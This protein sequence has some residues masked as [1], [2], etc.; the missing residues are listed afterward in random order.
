MPHTPLILVIALGALALPGAAQAGSNNLWA[1]VNICDTEAHPSMMGVRARMPGDGTHER[2][3]M[4]FTAQY[5]GDERWRTVAG[6]GT[7]RWLFVGS[8]RFRFQEIGYT[9]KFT[10]PEEGR[11]YVLRGLVQFQWRKDGKVVHRT[12]LYTQR[13]HASTGADPKG[14]SAKYCRIG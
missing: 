7:S 8:A 1:T 14:Y 5:R 2:M 4:R 12:H 11:R 13:G 3:Y 10:P 9:F 6:R